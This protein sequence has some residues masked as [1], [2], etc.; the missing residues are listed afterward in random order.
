MDKA[1]ILQEVKANPALLNTP[2]AKAVMQQNGI[3]KN[4]VLDRVNGSQ[5]PKDNKKENVSI[6]ND[7]TIETQDNNLNKDENNELF[8]HNSLLKFVPERTLVKRIQSIRQTEKKQ[9]LKRYG[10]KFFYN[11]NKLNTS[12]L[13]VPKYYILNK[14]DTIIIQTFGG[15]NKTFKLTI[16]NNGNIDLPILG[17]IYVAGMQL[18]ELQTFMQKKLKATYPNSKLVINVKVNSFIQVSLTGFTPA[19]GIYNLTSLATVKDLL[20]TAKGFGKLGS[21][22]NVELKR[23]GKTI[24]IIDFYKL[25]KDGNLIDRSLLRNGDI[26]FIPK[27]QTLVNLYGAVNTPAIYELKKEENLQDL[28]YFA[29]G[30]QVKA[31]SKHI[32]ITSYQNDHTEVFFTSLKENKILKNGD[33]IYVYKF[34]QLN[35]E[36]VYAY[37]NI[38]KPGS[39]NIPKDKKL[40]TLLSSLIFL[41]DTYYEYGLIEK[42]NGKIISFEINNPNDIT[43]ETQDKIYIFNKYE[44]LP[45]EFVKIQGDVVKNPGTYKY[46]E[47]ITLEDLIISAGITQPFYQEKIKIINYDENMKP[48]LRFVDYTKN[49]QLKLQPYDEITLFNFYYFDPLQPIT[50]KGGVHKPGVYI[51]TKNM[52]LKDLLTVAGWVSNKVDKSY[53][54]LTRTEIKNNKHLRSTQKLTF[55]DLDQIL[56]PND[57]VTIFTL[58]SIT[59]L[60]SVSISGEVTSPGKYTYTEGMTLSDLLNLA[61]DL[62]DKAD[63]SHIELI[64]YSIENNKRIRSI[65]KLSLKENIQ[66]KPYDEI[67]IK[68]IADWNLKKSVEIRGEVNYPGVYTMEKGDTLYDIIQ[69]AGGFTKDAYLYGAVF[70]RE[71]VRKMQQDRLNQM[72]YKLKKKITVI[73]ASA[74]S[75]GE[76]TFDAK[77]SIDA[78]DNLSQQAQSLKPIGRIALQLDKDLEKFKTSQYNIVLQNKDKLYIPVKLDSVT[79]LGEVLTPTAFVYTTESS[80]EYIEQAGGKTEMAEDTYFVVHANGFTE[81]GEFGWCD[82]NLDVKSGDV[83]TLPIKIETS[84]WFGISKDLT[85]IVYQLSITAASLKAVGAL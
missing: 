69:R 8:R 50:I 52:T 21:M 43:L 19:P 6:E 47:G 15:S 12:I 26:I 10:S 72:I 38:D 71:S 76:S 30:L 58:D 45:K 53:I 59:P 42:F 20:I 74:K 13:S 44:I 54:K 31:S 40:K 11:K 78:I 23:G 16:D 36:F 18:E 51:Y 41:K 24:K 73:S 68:R 63:T 64:R 35:K 77:N 27:A 56:Q 83:I 66:L 61:K 32:K 39:Y 1:A 34:S 29:G 60:Q 84:T 5:T 7:I 57:E 22:R 14:G 62:T 9:N 37:G 48:V 17:P 82:D 28:I 85:S 75:A 4:E 33:N 25:I 70:T 65:Q 2:Q 55:N 49:K 67:S 46:L 80:L 3:S 81:K 79:V